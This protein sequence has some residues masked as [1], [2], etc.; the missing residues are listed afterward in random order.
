MSYPIRHGIWFQRKDDFDKV[1]ADLKDIIDYTEKDKLFIH[2]ESYKQHDTDIF[3]AIA[4]KYPEMTCMGYSEYCCMGGGSG[5]SITIN[6]GDVNVQEYESFDDFSDYEENETD[7]EPEENKL[8]WDNEELD[9][10][11]KKKFNDFLKKISSL[12]YALS[13]LKH[14]LE[15]LDKNFENSKTAREAKMWADIINRFKIV[16]ESMESILAYNDIVNPIQKYD[17]T[18]TVDAR[19]EEEAKEIAC[20]KIGTRRNIPAPF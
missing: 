4:K 12:V 19:S 15:D 16:E 20:R 1:A 18:V 6:R 3:E 8:D 17:V 13:D 7:T 2:W 11:Q 14:I 9:E 10:N 5:L